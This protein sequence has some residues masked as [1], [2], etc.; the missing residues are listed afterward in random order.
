MTRNDFPAMIDDMGISQGA[1]IG[2][3]MGEFSYALLRHSRIK[4]LWS[5]DPW[6]GKTAPTYEN[7]ISLLSEFGLRSRIVCETSEA[8]GKIARQDGEK[9]GFVYIDGDHLYQSVKND[10]ETWLPLLTTPGILAGH[11]YL[12]GIRKCNVIPAVNETAEK[13]GLPISLTREKWASWFFV[14]G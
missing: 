12:T 9:F 3:N 2:V 10:I 8:A 14:I 11:D 1:E 13:L 7:A 4:T 5:V 6:V